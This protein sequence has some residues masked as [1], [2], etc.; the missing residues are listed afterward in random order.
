MTMLPA[1]PATTT[2]PRWLPW[3]F[4]GLLVL[5]FHPYWV[6][7][8]QVRRGLLLLLAGLSL[9]LLPRLP[10]VR[11]ENA[12][13]VFFGLLFVCAVISMRSLQPWEAFYRLAHWTALLV[14]LRLGAAAHGA[15][16]TPLAAV[17]LATSLLG[18]L[19]RFGLAEVLGYGVE[20]EPVSV[21]GNLNVASEW[22]AVAAMAVAVLGTSRRWLGHTALVAA[23]AYLV[24]AQSR[25]GLVALPIGLLLLV[26]LR[27]R[28]GGPIAL[29]LA[30]AGAG[31]GFLVQTTVSAPPSIDQRV[32]EAEQK[33]AGATLE[34]R[35]E[36][37]RGCT[38]LF[39]ERPLFGWGPGQFAV[40]YPRVR[41]QREIELSSHGRQFATE[42]RTAHDDWLELLVE[43]GLP[44]LLAFAL[45]LFALQRGNRDKARLLPL[46]VLLLLMFVRAPLGNAPA[47]ATALL[48]VG[49][50]APAPP[51]TRST[52]WLHRAMGLLLAVSGLL[53]LVA[54]CLFV[55][56]QGAV[57]NGD[58]PPR[59][60]LERAIAWMWWEPRWWQLLAQEQ[61]ASGELSNARRHSS[62]AY[63]LR[64]HDPQL[65]L[66]V[67]EV[68]ARG[69]AYKEAAAIADHALQLDPGNPELRV[70]LSTARLQQKDVD[71]A[72]EAVVT[73]PHPTLRAQLGNHFRALEKLAA[74]NGDAVGAARCEFE[75]TCLEVLETIGD[76]TPGAL[77]TTGERIKVLLGAA[78]RAG[79]QRKDLRPYALSAA[80]YL[81][82]GDDKA[83]GE[84]ARA[85]QKLTTEL[86]A[87]QR[88][89]LEPVL[90]KLRQEPGWRDVLR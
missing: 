22:T 73:S 83:V 13:Y 42:V 59:A 60:P 32:L 75:R 27:A 45:A 88:E 10:R 25:S 44:V 7:F 82:L 89:Q 5:P 14:V 74:A 55:P 62:V 33:R 35:Y 69:T 23:G 41:S 18:L 65:Q 78:G 85:A 64:P 38:Q 16:A 61:L 50:Q 67:G 77:A 86:P 39:A 20:R 57:A 30:L 36:I 66:L 3:T 79:L 87:W 29:L 71:G 12:G 24:V 43:G 90:G 84:L 2:V 72:I 80:H 51:T 49:T 48:L 68:L 8:E 56:Y 53:P 54:H 15:F 52:A 58:A 21:F 11:G 1:A 34:V 37:A 70:L 46:F 17:L 31:A 63:T 81:T 47:V 19:Q 6:D 28:N 4:L 26:F 9:V 76:P 40:Q